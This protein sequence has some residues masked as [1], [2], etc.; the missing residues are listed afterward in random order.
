MRK[1]ILVDDD[2]IF[3]FIHQKVIQ[4]AC[5][6]A[7]I[8]IYQ[9][10]VEA[11]KALS[12]Q[13]TA[14]ITIE[15]TLFLDINMP[16]LNGFELLDKLHEGFQEKQLIS[17][18]MVSSTLNDKDIEKALSYPCVKGFKSKPLKKEDV[19]TICGC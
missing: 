15:T 10:S 18:F 14:G 4:Q 5:P 6:N 13:L 7:V 16:E 19:A 11:L 12:D 17:A 1:F 8:E 2:Q 9:S 3:N